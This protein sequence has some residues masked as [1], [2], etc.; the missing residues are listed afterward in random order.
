[1]TKHQSRKGG[2]MGQQTLLRGTQRG[3]SMR[4]SGAQHQT[5]SL[6]G[7]R[8][9]ALGVADENLGGAPLY[10]PSRTAT[11]LPKWGEIGE[12]ERPGGRGR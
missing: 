2:Q 4:I 3:L 1:M 7:R 5:S 12:A 8:V 6:R 9:E 11:V 10:C